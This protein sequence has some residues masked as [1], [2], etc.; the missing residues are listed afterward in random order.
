MAEAKWYHIMTEDWEPSHVRVFSNTGTVDT[1]GNS[2]ERWNAVRIKAESEEKALEGFLKAYYRNPERYTYSAEHRFWVK[3]IE[4]D[5]DIEITTMDGEKVSAA[6]VDM[7][8][9]NRI[10]RKA[11]GLR[12]IKNVMDADSDDVKG[13]MWFI[14]Q[15]TLQNYLMEL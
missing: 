11:T 6:L 4:T 2:I 8:K 1:N 10:A 7:P 12:Y 3:E 9:L 14:N 5:D 15:D 13:Y